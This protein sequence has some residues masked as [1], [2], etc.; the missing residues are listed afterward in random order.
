MIYH[1]HIKDSMSNSIN[2][3]QIMLLV[4]FESHHHRTN[5]STIVISI[6]VKHEII[7]GSTKKNFSNSSKELL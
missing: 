4:I 5:I 3:D 6:L 2:L 7:A 1:F